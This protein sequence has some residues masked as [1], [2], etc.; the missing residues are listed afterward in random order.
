[1]RVIGRPFLRQ[2]ALG[3]VLNCGERMLDHEDR[4]YKR[5]YLGTLQR[6]AVVSEAGGTHTSPPLDVLNLPPSQ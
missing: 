3:R 4:K 6:L 1:M 2:L 5:G